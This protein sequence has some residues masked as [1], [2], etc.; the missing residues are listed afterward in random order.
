MYNLVLPFYEVHDL[1]VTVVLSGNIK[2]FSDVERL[3][4]AAYRKRNDISLRSAKVRFPQF[5]E[6]A[7]RINQMALEEF[8]RGGGLL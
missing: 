3:R 1:Q 5:N 6:F 8:F 4:Y 2:E 7:K